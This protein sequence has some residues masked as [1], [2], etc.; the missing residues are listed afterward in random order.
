MRYLDMR[1][2]GALFLVLVVT[3]S[4]TAK[5]DTCDISQFKNYMSYQQ[6]ILTNL[7]YIHRVASREDRTKSDNADLK[8]QDYGSLTY[9]QAST[10]ATSLEKL[11]DIK[12][13]P[14]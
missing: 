4:S 5:A 3:S 12:W 13:S 7:S 6:D 1:Y 2:L 14:I 11:L 10:F 9:G 8:V